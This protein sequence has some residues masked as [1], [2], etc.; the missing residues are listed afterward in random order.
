VNKQ[1]DKQTNRQTDTEAS[2]TGL[3]AKGIMHTNVASASNGEDAPC[4]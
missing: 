3:H 4:R 2:I 1:T